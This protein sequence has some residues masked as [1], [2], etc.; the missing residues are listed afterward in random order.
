MSLKNI[1]YLIAFFSL[2]VVIYLLIFWRDQ[3]ISWFG[4]Q[5]LNLLYAIIMAI[6]VGL[7]LN[8]IYRKYS[9][10][11][12]LKTTVT[13]PR[14]KH[15]ILAK[16]VLKE[17]HE[18]I[19]KEYER[20]FG[21]EDFLGVAVPDDLLYVGKEHFKITRQDDGYYI[22]DL[23]TKNGTKINDEEIKGK[24]RR[25]LENEDEILVASTLNIRYKEK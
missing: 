15:K 2:L 8:Y 13:P 22:E 23:K 12:I 11:K 3:F 10:S 1:I 19:I 21:R 7:I 24:G 18:Y 14:N 4:A 17:N 6:I 16:L 5:S 25:K 20:V 9:Q